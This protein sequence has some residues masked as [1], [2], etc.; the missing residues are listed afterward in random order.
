[1]LLYSHEHYLY[2]YTFSQS[3][4]EHMKNKFSYLAIAIVSCFILVISQSVAAQTNTD[5]TKVSAA[6]KDDRPSPPK[7]VEHTIGD[8]KVKIQYSAPGVKGRAIWGEL[9]PYGKVWRTGANEATTIEVSRDCKVGNGMIKA[10]KYALF[11]I[12][13]EKEWTFIFN[14]VPDQWGAYKYEEAKDALRVQAKPVES[15]E[16]NDRLKFDITGDAIY[17]GK[18]TLSWDKLSVAFDI[19]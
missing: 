16:F 15:Q 6:K 13:G 18:V 4:N 5:K 10:G 12:P 2:L 14:S 3:K 17:G 9:V 7:V 19:R 1:L 11:S 8:L